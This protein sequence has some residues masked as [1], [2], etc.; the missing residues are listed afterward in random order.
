[1]WLRW[2]R[3]VWAPRTAQARAAA[4]QLT[5]QDPAPLPCPQGLCTSASQ[6]STEQSGAVCFRVPANPEIAWCHPT[7]ISAQQLTAVPVGASTYL[8]HPSTHVRAERYQTRDFC[9]QLNCFL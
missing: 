8:V 7:S 9:R 6:R 4:E 5:L 3:P 2:R 1:M